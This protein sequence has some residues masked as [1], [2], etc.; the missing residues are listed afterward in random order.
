MDASQPHPCTAAR[1][2][3][4][5]LA[6]RPGPRPRHHGQVP[7]G[8]AAPQPAPE[9]QHRAEGAWSSALGTVVQLRVPPPPKLNPSARGA[10]GPHAGRGRGWPGLLASAHHAQPLH[11]RLGTPDK[12]EAQDI[13]GHRPDEAERR[14]SYA[15]FGALGWGCGTEGGS[16][17]EA[18]HLTRHAVTSVSGADV[19]SSFRAMSHGSVSCAI[20]VSWAGACQNPVNLKSSETK[21]FKKK[22]ARAE[23]G[24]RL[25][26]LAPATTSPRAP[27]P[28]SWGASPGLGPVPWASRGPRRAIDQGGGALQCLGT[29]QVSSPAAPQQRRAL[30]TCGGSRGLRRGGGQ[31]GGGLCPT[32][33]QGQGPLSV[34]PGPSPV[35][36]LAQR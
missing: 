29:R 16:G 28:G 17:G 27:A 36:G 5:P 4:P 9:R 32:W 7:A 20:S 22:K 31:L 19:E 35:C 14:G 10:W 15:Q 26:V 24:P 1:L 21:K 12:G 11:G 23:G 6:S 34:P 8:G 25:G 13:R 2:P 3:T 33:T 30:R 18:W